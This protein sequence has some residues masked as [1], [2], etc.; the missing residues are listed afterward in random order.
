MR[1]RDSARIMASKFFYSTRPTGRDAPRAITRSP[2]INA[3]RAMQ[4]EAEIR[5]NP[6]MCADRFVNDWRSWHRNQIGKA[7]PMFYFC[8]PGH[9]GEQVEPNGLP[10][11]S[12]QL[13]HHAPIPMRETG[14]GDFG[15]L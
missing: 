13:H 10:S 3:I 8:D 11:I 4:L 9:K 5:T 15:L 1:V 12:L 2:I 7:D 6:Q 14:G